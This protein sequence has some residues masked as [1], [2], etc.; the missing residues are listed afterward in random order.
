MLLI[1]I[2]TACGYQNILS[3]EKKNYSFF[4]SMV[5]L[6]LLKSLRN[7]C[8]GIFFLTCLSLENINVFPIENINNQYITLHR[9]FFTKKNT[10]QNF[11]VSF[12]T[13]QKKKPCSEK[14]N[15]ITKLIRLL[16]TSRGRL[17]NI[18]FQFLLTFFAWQTPH[19]FL[20][21]K[22]TTHVRIRKNPISID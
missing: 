5:F 6:F 15:T 13:E 9:I 2:K 18:T 12:A 4:I 7:I 21:I 17:L 10:T 16:F 19:V 3:P 8:Y 14:R 11:I 20:A 22:A 1:Q